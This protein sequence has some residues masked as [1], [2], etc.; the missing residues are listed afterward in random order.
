[1]RD[2]DQEIAEKKADIERLTAEKKALEEIA[3][4]IVLE[5]M[6]PAQRVAIALYQFA[7]GNYAEDWPY[8]IYN[9]VHDWTKFAHTALLDRATRALHLTGGNE[10]LVIEM[11]KII[12]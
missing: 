11:A 6:T 1:M 8:E 2:I 4:K 3:K 10:M 5:N 7:P 9:Y 12:R